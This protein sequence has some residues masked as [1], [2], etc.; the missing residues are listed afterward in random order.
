MHQKGSLDP[1]GA[2]HSAPFVRASDGAVRIDPADL[3]AIAAAMSARFADAHREGRRI[4]A[5]GELQISARDLSRLLQAW[6]SQSLTECRGSHGAWDFAT[7][8]RLYIEAL[9]DYSAT[10]RRV[11]AEFRSLAPT[12]VGRAD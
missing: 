11:A 8:N 9:A 6:V 10:V 4:A 12:V 7:T 2:T 5:L 1:V 3:E